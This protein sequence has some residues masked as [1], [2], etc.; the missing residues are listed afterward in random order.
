[1]EL[2]ALEC[3]EMD[4]G[5]HTW[6]KCCLRGLSLTVSTQGFFGEQHQA[7]R[8]RQ[9]LGPGAHPGLTSWVGWRR[10]GTRK[11]RCWDGDARSPPALGQDAASKGMPRT[12]T[13]LE[14]RGH[15]QEMS[16]WSPAMGSKQKK[17]S[18]AGQ[19]PAAPGCTRSAATCRG[20]RAPQQRG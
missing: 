11:R 8:T 17:K 19:P 7:V 4:K 12:E 16:F 10:G 18:R 9:E 2:S 1:M 14:A 15:G 6:P 3:S 5:D 13:G 20:L